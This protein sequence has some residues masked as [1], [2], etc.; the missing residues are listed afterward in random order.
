VSR[1]APFRCW[2]CG[3]VIPEDISLLRRE[4]TCTACGADLKVCK[5]CTFYNTSVSDACEEPIAGLVTNK[6]RANFCDY[7]TFSAK[8]YRGTASLPSPE[9]DALAALFGDDLPAPENVV[10][11]S[12]RSELDKLFGLDD[13]G[14]G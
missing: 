12:S 11:E 10:E 5:S 14:D 9:R 7:F 2:H 8:A 3:D 13:D 6:E 1:S 4:E